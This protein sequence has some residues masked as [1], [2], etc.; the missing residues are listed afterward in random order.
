MKKARR[1][2][3]FLFLLPLTPPAKAAEI[4]DWP[5][6]NKNPFVISLKGAHSSL[7]SHSSRPGGDGGLIVYDLNGDG[8][9]DYVITRPGQIAAYEH[10]GRLLWAVEANIVLST[11]S[12]QE[13]LPG[14]HAPGV[15]AGDP[16]ADGRTD[17]LFLSKDG[18]LHWLDGVTGNTI[19]RDVLKRPGGFP[20]WEHLVLCNLQ[21]NGD[22]D[23]MAQST[24][25]EGYRMGR[26]IAAYS[27]EGDSPALRWSSSDY[28]GCAHNGLRVADLDSDGKDEILG[29]TLFKSDGTL[30]PWTKPSRFFPAF[31]KIFRH[32]YVHFFKFPNYDG[33]LDSIFVDDVRPDIKNLEVVAL[34]EGQG[35]KTFLF[36]QEGLLW[37]EDHEWQEP[38]NAAL[39]EFDI[40]R[41]GLEIWC[42]SRHDVDQTPW[43]FSSTGA[44]IAAWEM[45]K[46]AP[47][48]WTN[49]GIEEIFTIHWDG[50]E[51]QYLAA[52]ERHKVGDVAIIDAM[53]GQFIKRFPEKAERLYVADVSGDW[54]EELLVLTE[55][56]IHIYFN[57]QDPKTAQKRLWDRPHY[58]RAKM[59][60]NYYSP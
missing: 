35:M 58:R 53:T 3:L 30:I 47:P 8:L 36:N 21:G 56:E 43:V 26:Y 25:Q 11:Q 44:V 14:L 54:R 1:A 40:T 4:S 32:R 45:K 28:L 42:R 37:A 24:N 60:Y 2:A 15:Q 7:D 57:Q 18:E 6:Y 12:E 41:P 48:G 34:Q 50:G 55:N 23:L 17:I 39:G 13:G 38:Q 9:L 16:N 59:T 31:L 33:H 49:E 10:F 19:R 27:L 20:Q 51:K 29:A 46:M 22:R 5:Q 52:K